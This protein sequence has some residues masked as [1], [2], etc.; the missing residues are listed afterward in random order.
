MLN[1]EGME[2]FLIV[3]AIRRK[4]ELLKVWTS[5]NGG[6]LSITTVTEKKPL[7][8]ISE[9]LQQYATHAWTFDQNPE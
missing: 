5:N 7:A 2:I 9:F 3:P 8:Q 1:L 4:T 6:E